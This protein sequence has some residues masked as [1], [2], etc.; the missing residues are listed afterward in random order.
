MKLLLAGATGLVGSHVLQLALRDPRIAQVIAPTR[1]PLPAHQKLVAPIVDFDALPTNADWWR[2]DAVICALGTTMKVAGSRTVFRRVDLDYPLT[3]AH[4]A[5][6]H[7]V[8]AYVLNSAMGADAGSRIFYNRT[9]G[10]LEQ[11]LAGIGFDSLTLVR[12]GLIG[13]TRSEFRL[14]ERAMTLALGAASPLL[15]KRWR[16]NPASRIAQA[17]LDAAV[18]AQPGMRVIGSQALA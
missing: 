7:G 6:A 16:I 8:P 17:M 13:G 15:P 12:P 9:K 1:R 18:A 2:V 10:E 4:I 3:V 5:H 11:A 14:G